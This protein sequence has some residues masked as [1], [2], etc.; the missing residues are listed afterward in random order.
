MKFCWLLILKKKKVWRFIPHLST[1]N[2]PFSMM[3]FLTKYQ[4]CFANN[5]T[6]DAYFSDLKKSL[7]RR[8]SFLYLND[9]KTPMT[10]FC[11]VRPAVL[12]TLLFFLW[13]CWGGS[14]PGPRGTSSR[15]TESASD[16][17]GRG[18]PST[19]VLISSIIILGRARRGGLAWPGAPAPRWSCPS[20]QW[21]HLYGLLV[22][23][24]GWLVVFITSTQLSNRGESLLFNN[25]KAINGI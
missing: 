21:L 5:I 4:F 12:L 6:T 10:P 22:P 2:N 17:L 9:V 24:S 1:E 8:K 16:L 19:L 25:N 7:S 15:H 18:D 3:F 23:L 11:V 14:R 20:W 13:T